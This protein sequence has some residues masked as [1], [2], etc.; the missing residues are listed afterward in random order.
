[1]EQNLGLSSGLEHLRRRNLVDSFVQCEDNK[2]HEEPLKRQETS[3]PVVPL[4]PGTP[5]AAVHPPGMIG[6]VNQPLVE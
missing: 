1:M 2:M 5:Q 4:P 6:Y 3:V